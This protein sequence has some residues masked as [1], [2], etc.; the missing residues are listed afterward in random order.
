MDV[1]SDEI[2]S[3]RFQGTRHVYDR[4]EVDAFLHRT[5]ATLEVY[6]RKLAVTQAHVE[7]LEKALDLA[8]GRARSVRSRETRIADLESALAAAQHNYESAMAMLEAQADAPQTPDVDD[9]ELVL[10]ARVRVEEILRDAMQEVERTRAESE[11]INEAAV[12]SARKE[13]DE[14]LKAASLEHAAMLEE[15]ARARRDAKVA[16]EA[17][18][19][20]KRS[21]ALTEL[22]A[23]RVR[24][25]GD[26]AAAEA[27]LEARI[28]KVERKAAKSA[29]KARKQLQAAEDRAAEA[30][31]D[32]TRLL[33]EIERAAAAAEAERKVFMEDA[34]R[35]FEEA[36][37]RA[38]AERDTAMARPA[39]D[40]AEDV[41]VE[42]V[43]LRRQVAQLRTALAGVQKRF[44]DISD[45]S[46]EEL[47][48]SAMLAGLEAGDGDVIDL[49]TGATE[50]ST[51]DAGPIDAPDSSVTVKSRWADMEPMHAAPRGELETSGGE[52]G[53]TAAPGGPTWRDAVGATRRAERADEAETGET[54]VIGFY[55]R[56]LAGLRARLKDAAPPD[57]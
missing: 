14:L 51:D 40:V 57:V 1:T 34:E 36:V 24:L 45:V 46:I 5:A 56:R 42:V 18:L 7:S 23:E 8:H 52:S 22:E 37:A 19:D 10:A 50:G 53:A 4:R 48:L 26:T 6:E 3:S 27:G 33:E 29:E 55:E 16:L 32:R 49:T 20:A 9:H 44:S 43:Q 41:S 35:M 39:E 2:R 28:A 13:A 54:A 15:V 12:D 30:E 31:A 47:E 38:E 25:A 17:E 21:A 11:Q